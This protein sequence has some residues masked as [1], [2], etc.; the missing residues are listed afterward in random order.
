MLFR[1]KKD[2]KK[3]DFFYAYFLQKV[4]NEKKTN[5]AYYYTTY[6]AYKVSKSF[7]DTSNENSNTDPTVDEKYLPNSIIPLRPENEETLRFL[8]SKISSKRYKLTSSQIVQLNETASDLLK[9][10]KY[11]ICTIVMKTVLREMLMT[12]YMYD[13]H[14]TIH[15]YL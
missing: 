8:V 7:Y 11:S 2:K 4:K 1:R 12:F 14:Q 10:E 5:L 15:F 13:I 3:Q 9:V 6:H